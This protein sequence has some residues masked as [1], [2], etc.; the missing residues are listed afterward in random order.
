MCSS[1]HSASTIEFM[2]PAGDQG[3]ITHD[4]RPDATLAGMTNS[5]GHRSIMWFRR[6][7]RLGDHPALQHAARHG[8]EVVPA[9]I[10]DPALVGPSGAARLAFMYRSLRA[11][12]ASIG[13]ALIVRHGRPETVIPQLAHDVGADEVVV[14]RD[15]APYGRRRDAAVIEHLAGL[16]ISFVGKDTPYAVAPGTVV[17][18]NG[19][20]YAVFTPFSKAW[21]ALADQRPVDAPAVNWYRPRIDHDPVPAD[22]AID[23]ELPDANEAAAHALWEDFLG[24][25]VD[26]YG[27]RRNN[28][29]ELGT[30]RLSP[31]LRW[32]QI[33]PRQLLADLGDSNGANT[34]RKELAWREFYAD[35]LFHHPHSARENL[36]TKMN[37]L[38]VDTDT[39]ARLR[40]DRWAAG[41]TGYPIVDA[42]MRQLLATGWM[43]NRVRM[44]TASF[45]VKDLHLPWQWGAR[46]FMLH[47]V[48]GDLASNQHGWQWTAG[49]GTDAAP[50]YRVFNPVLQSERFDPHGDYIRQWVPELAGV[51]SM[52]IHQ[53]V[54]PIVDHGDERAEA[55]SRYQA[56]T[57]R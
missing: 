34:F 31:Y 13:G 21:S 7:L 27:S 14:T 41:R 12:D 6:D 35:V 51:T 37:A 36:Q 43:H 9:F 44:I 3:R 53:A 11:L 48:D 47:L 50:Y 30:S 2:D 22:P 1:L 26:Q 24:D 52:A 33:H 54:D 42:G 5:V 16:D 28:P 17:K 20:P 23:C 39:A 18:D 29:G 8:R 45:L 40:F 46:H 57:G 10:V 4:R 32:G 15:Y 25:G 49:S 55:L 38:P 56:V 19:T